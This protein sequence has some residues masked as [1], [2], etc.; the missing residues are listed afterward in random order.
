VYPPAVDEEHSGN[1]DLAQDGTAGTGGETAL[2][3]R[4]IELLRERVA[5]KDS[6]I[7]DL[8]VRL[9]QSEQER[10]EKDR[11]LTALLS[12]QRKRSRRRWLWRRKQVAGA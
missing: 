12:D 11:Q 3:H 7:E 2:L 9:D 4:E 5:D 6:V 10:R 1:P 8:R